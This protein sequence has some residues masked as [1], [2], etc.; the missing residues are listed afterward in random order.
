MQ[1][2]LGSNT[3]ACNGKPIL[4]FKCGKPGH[5]KVDCPIGKEGN[6]GTSNGSARGSSVALDTQETHHACM[7][8]ACSFT[9]TKHAFCVQVVN[10]PG[11]VEPA[12]IVTA[13]W[14]PSFMMQKPMQGYGQVPTPTITF[15]IP[16]VMFCHGTVHPDS[17]CHYGA[18]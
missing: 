18:S 13:I 2:V 12:G 9:A 17:P 10:P 14:L 15:C 11:Y 3:T 8:V 1:V 7:A 16:G 6:G 5:K 4:C